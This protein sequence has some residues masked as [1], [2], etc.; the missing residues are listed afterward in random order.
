MTAPV[1]IGLVPSESPDKLEREFNQL[2]AYLEA[3]MK[4]PV[5]VFIPEDYRVMIKAMKE[6]SVDIG[7]FGP[8][9]YVI[10]DTQQDLIPL[11]VRK[12]REVGLTYNSLIITRK[13][14]DIS[15]IEDL[16][17]RCMAF[18]NPASTSGYIIPQSLFIS[19]NLAVEEY[20]SRYYFAG[21]HDTAV[22][23]VLKGAC[24]AG[25]VSNTVLRHLIDQKLVNPDD[26][27]II[28]TSEA[29]PGSPYIAR[30]NLKKSTIDAFSRAMLDVHI[31]APEALE[32][33]DSSIE[34]YLPIKRGM[35]NPIRNIVH[36]L[37]RDFIEKNYL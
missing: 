23:D 27:R 19:R 6:E 15:T 22:Q 7:L 10:A 1:V 20:L 28:W 29:I 25:A 33:F 5:E 36:I 2:K 35:Y 14:S 32:A 34:Q 11:L 9:S 17:G 16:K 26:L 12:K 3:E 13:D 37:G 8:F 31:E 30:G 21:T 4:R 18:V 24:D